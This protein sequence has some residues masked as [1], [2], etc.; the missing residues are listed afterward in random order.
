MPMLVIG[1]LASIQVEV[2]NG[3]RQWTETCDQ[4]MIAIGEQAM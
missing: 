3:K 4:A 2:K 1:R